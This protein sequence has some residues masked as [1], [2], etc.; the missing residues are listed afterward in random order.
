MR[1]LGLAVEAVEPLKLRPTPLRLAWREEGIGE[2]RER[3]GAEF[4]RGKGGENGLG[5]SA[6]VR[7]RDFL[8]LIEEGADWERM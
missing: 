1:P 2:E 3:V 4:P 5:S 7:G 6:E 8:S